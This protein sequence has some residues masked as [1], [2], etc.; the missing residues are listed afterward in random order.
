MLNDRSKNKVMKMKT[1]AIVVKA[2]QRFELPLVISKSGTS[3]HWVFHSKGYDI[4][5]GFLKGTNK[6]SFVAITAYPPDTPQQGK[7]V[8]EEVGEYFLVW[9]NT[10]SWF[11]EKNVVYS[12]DIVLPELTL[13]EKVACARYM[14]LCICECLVLFWRI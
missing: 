10:Y 2:G 13:D 3:V 4:R 14:C 1:N 8:F 11:H 9:D 6:E 5:F 12:V 7:I